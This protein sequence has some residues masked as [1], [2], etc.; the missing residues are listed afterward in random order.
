MFSKISEIIKGEIQEALEERPLVVKTNVG[1]EKDKGYNWIECTDTTLQIVPEIDEKP[2]LEGFWTLRRWE[3]GH[4]ICNE[5]MVID[6]L[7]KLGYYIDL[8]PEFCQCQ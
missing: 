2:F 7:V 3:N 5:E 6:L 1:T 8:V 4:E